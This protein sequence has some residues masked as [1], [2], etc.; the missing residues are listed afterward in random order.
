MGKVFAGKID[1]IC[2]E[3]GITLDDYREI[4]RIS[5]ATTKK[6]LAEFKPALKACDVPMMRKIIHKM[7]GT[8]L[9]LGMREISSA[10]EAVADAVKNGHNKKKITGILEKLEKHFHRYEKA[11]S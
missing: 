9:T 6:D 3:L 2:R 8:Y 10:I 5:I 11:V 7:R 1:E 4:A